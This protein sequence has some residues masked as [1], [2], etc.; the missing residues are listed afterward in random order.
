ML[1]A[2]ALAEPRSE[3]GA[4]DGLSSAEAAR[5]RAEFGPNAVVEDRAHPLA[6][7]E[8]HFWAPVPWMLETTI[9]LQVATGERLEASMIAALLLLN[10]ALGVFQENRAGAALALLKDQLALKARVR[11]DGRW[12]EVPA[13]DLVPGDMIQLS[14]GSIVPADS[15]ILAGI[16]LLDQSMLTGESIPTEAE[17][18]KVAYAEAIVRRGE[19]IAEIIATGARTYF[20]RAAELV[21]TA[22][23]E[24][25]EQQAV[26]GV[27]RNLTIVNFAIIVGIVA[28]AH[29]IAM[30]TT[31]IIPLVLTALLSA[32]PVALPA[33][34]TLAATLGAKTLALKGVLLT[35]LSALHEAAMIDVL[36]VDK[37]GTLTL[38]ELAVSAVRGVSDGYSE[39]AV[40]ALAALAS[41]PDGRDPV[42]SVIR[43]MARQGGVP[44]PP[45]VVRFTPFDPTVKL[46]EAVAQ[47]ASANEIRIVKGA[48]A[49]IAAT[50]PINP[51]IFAEL[52]SLASA[53]YRVLTVAC[54]PPGA[55]AIVGLIAFGDPLRPE[56]SQLARRARLLGCGHS[57]GHWRCRGHRCDR[58]TSSWA[59]GTGVSS[60][61]DPRQCQ[62][63]RFRDLCRCIPGRQVSA[64]QG[65]S[66]A[67][68]RRR[69]VRRRRQ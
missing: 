37:T 15:R 60:G 8:R 45:K 9:A 49:A 16:L 65:V 19:A 26:L 39:G 50:A 29:A 53:G 61:R 62:S 5:R 24:S 21:R 4:A 34:F 54:G 27:V 58:R 18:D 69:D 2:A 52:Q 40:L 63:R 23:V 68:P 35:R 56:L 17:R 20:G 14:L 55:M 33:T 48:P 3:V 47:D 22:H 7:I 10:V 38:N 11:R 1:T 42:D 25:S 57:H 46:A 51:R 13:V 28:Y 44:L 43:S 36:C 59:G 66:A 31:R 41:S 67:G 6:R 12:I 32:V 30:S 64:G